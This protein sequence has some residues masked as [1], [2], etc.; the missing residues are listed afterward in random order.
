MRHVLLQLLH[1]LA[2]TH[3]AV[4]DLQLPH[5]TSMNI[6]CSPENLLKATKLYCGGGGGEVVSRAR[7]PAR[8]GVRGEVERCSEDET[9]GCCLY[10]QASRCEQLDRF[11]QK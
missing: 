4:S 1:H 5:Y 3:Y 10:T 9:N 2:L 6:K 11:I 8:L 7:W